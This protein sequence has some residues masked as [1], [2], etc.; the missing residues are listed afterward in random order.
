MTSSV[1][2]FV[3]QDQIIE[4]ENPDPNQTLLSY[5]RTKLKKTGTKEGCAEGGCGACTVVLGELKNNK[6]K[7]NSINSC[8]M[9]LPMLQGKQLILVEDLVSKGGLL[10]PVQQAMVNYHGSQC[11]FCTP[12]FVMSLFS[13]FKNHSKFKD[14]IINESISGNLCRCTGYQPIIKAAKS[15][16]RKNKIDHFVKNKNNIISLLKKIKDENI[17]IYE[18]EKR[19]FAPKYVQELKKILKKNINSRFISGGTDLSLVVT[20]GKKR[21]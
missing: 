14:S 18:K 3:H 2:K 10:H 21:N 13:M 17:V 4:V 16:K 9:F 12:G 6:I 19:Y 7:Y 5:I 11:G 1:I 8:I 15:L 20:K